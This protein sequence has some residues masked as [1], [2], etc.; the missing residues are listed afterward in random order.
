MPALAQ[1]FE[2]YTL[3]R[4]ALSARIERFCEVLQQD[5]LLD[6]RIQERLANLLLRLRENRLMVAFVAEFSWGKFALINAIFFSEYGNRVL[7]SSAGRTTMCPTELFYDVKKPHGVELLPIETRA[8]DGNVSDY[9]LQQDA[10]EFIAIDIHSSESMANALKQVRET[11]KVSV[12]QAQRLGFEIQENLKERFAELENWVQ[13]TEEK[14]HHVQKMSQRIEE[15]FHQ[16]AP[17]WQK[18]A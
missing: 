17:N 4:R 7:P 5:D 18:S 16:N 15:M 3:W 11:Q 13:E 1:K 12:E 9:R 6:E 10:W 14:M 2:D 8:T